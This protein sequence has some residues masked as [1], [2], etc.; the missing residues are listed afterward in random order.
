MR[1]NM[2]DLI[3]RNGKVVDGSGLPAY[4]ADVGVKDGVIVKIGPITEDA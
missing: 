4:K 1:G 2:L 3:I